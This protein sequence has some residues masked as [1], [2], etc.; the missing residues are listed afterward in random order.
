MKILVVDDEDLQLEMLR[1][2]IMEVEPDCALTGFTNPVEALEWAK[3][4]MPEVAFLDIQM[5]VMNGITLAKALK[6]SNPKINLVFVTGCYTQYVF[7]AIPLHF[8]GYLQKPANAQKIRQELSNLRYPLIRQSTQRTIRVKCFGDFEVYADG[9]PLAFSRIKSKE[10]FAYLVDRKGSKVNGNKICSVVYEDTENE[11]SNKSNLR[12]C[13][14]DIRET[15]H[16]AGA[17]AVLLKGWDSYAIDTAQIECDYY[18]WEKNEPY[19][20]HSFRGE[21]MSQYSWAEH[22]LAYILDSALI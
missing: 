3:E 22:T 15:L 19:A 2:S 8:S 17:D 7:E 20:V 16:A 10:V 6:S 18:D 12:S 5:P 21:Y 9:K 11:A 4:N 14:A 1:E 13:I